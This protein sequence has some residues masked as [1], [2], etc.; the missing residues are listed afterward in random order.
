VRRESVEVFN[1]DAS[2]NAS[3]GYTT[4]LRLSSRMATQRSIEATTHTAEF[5]GRSVLDLGCGDGFYTAR[6]RHW[7]QFGWRQ[8]N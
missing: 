2:A 3:Y 1:R 4:G 6:M 8:A 5:T 7:R